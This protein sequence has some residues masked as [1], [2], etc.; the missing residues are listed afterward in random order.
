MYFFILTVGR[1]ESEDSFYRSLASMDEVKLKLTEDWGEAQSIII[2]KSPEVVILDGNIIQEKGISA[3][4]RVKS[5]NSFAKVFVVAKCPTVEMAV[6]SIRAGADEFITNPPDL[7]K[8]RALVKEEVLGWRMRA[9]G[10]GFDEKVETEYDFSNIIGESK[11][12]RKVFGLL[13]KVIPSRNAT[14]LIRGDT[15]TGKGVIARAIHYNTV[16]DGVSGM[17][18]PFVEIN[19]TAIPD[20]LLE[21]E[22][23]GYERGAFTDAKSSKKGLFELADGGTIFLDEIGYMNQ[24]LQIKIL[25]IVEEKNF[26][27]LGGTNDIRVDLRIIA[28]TN[29]DLEQAIEDGQFR[30]DLYYRLNVFTVELPLLKVRADDIKL[31]AKY[32]LNVFNREHRR[33]IRGFT[34]EAI[35]KMMNYQWP[36]NVR[37]LKNVVER[38]ILMVDGDLITGGN[39][40]IDS[41][42]NA[43]YE[44]ERGLSLDSNVVLELNGIG[45]PLEMAEKEVVEKVLKLNDGNRSKTAKIL[46]ISR[47]KLLRMIKK[48]SIDT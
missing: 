38:A 16:W 20:N 36:G 23:F 33:Q 22:L 7:M 26:R 30:R 13:K 5:L 15:G 1:S 45:I 43:G 29:Q 25:K 24:N 31:L 19:C 44:L 32:Y 6:G 11:E 2:D 8:L 41:D 9:F 18:S 35:A 12:I 42:Q 3:I 14:V 47:P 40:P 37:E 4:S 10:G 27:K 34:D 21:S 48:Y 17:E 46:E 39:L 28:G